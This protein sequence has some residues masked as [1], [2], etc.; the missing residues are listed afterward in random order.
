MPSRGFFKMSD[1]ENISACEVSNNRTL[2]EKKNEQR[3][4]LTTETELDELV[5]NAQAQSTKTKTI[6]AVNIFKGRRHLNIINI[7][8]ISIHKQSNAN[9]G[10][11]ID[12]YL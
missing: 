1:N 6:Y 12:K 9:L 10:S 3:F 11:N 7:N 5:S 2:N 4:A 8:N